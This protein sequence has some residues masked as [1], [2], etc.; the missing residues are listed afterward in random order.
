MKNA[1]HFFILATKDP[2][3]I[4][5]EK[6]FNEFAKVVEVFSKD[7]RMFRDNIAGK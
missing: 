5:P 1:K 6:Q 2:E 7:A 4:I 3:F